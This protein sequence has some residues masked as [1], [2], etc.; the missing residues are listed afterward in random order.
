MSDLW[1]DE[2]QHNSFDY[3]RD[4]VLYNYGEDI[5]A[6]RERIAE[7]ESLNAALDVKYNSAH[8]SLDQVTAENQRL[9]NELVSLGYGQEELAAL[10]G[11][12]EN[13]AV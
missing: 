7:L 13:G 2:H 8:Q 3:P 4:V 6:L 5:Q 10:L 11:G 9:R 1:Y 12:G